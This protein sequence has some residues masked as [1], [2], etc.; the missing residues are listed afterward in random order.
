MDKIEKKEGYD[1]FKDFIVQITEGFE[2]G[3]QENQDFLRNIVNYFSFGET[4]LDRSKGL[5]I[6]GAIGVGK[7]AILRLIQKWLPNNKK[8]AYNPCNEVVAQFNAIGEEGIKVYKTKRDRLFDDLG[9]EE[10]GINY[11]NKI[12]VFE[13]IIYS[14]YDQIYDGMITHFTT[15]LNDNQLIDKYGER[16]F[17]RLKDMCQPITWKGVES[18]RGGATFKYKRMEQEKKEIT[19][20][21]KKAIRKAYIDQCFLKPYNSMKNNGRNEFDVQCCVEFFKMLYR[22][23][24]IMPTDEQIKDCRNRALNWIES[25]ETSNEK[26]YKKARIIKQQI[27]DL[28]NGETNEMESKVKDVSAYFFFLDY[29]RKLIQDNTNIKQFLETNNF[30]EI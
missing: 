19:Q 28:R 20:E 7:T 30:Y 13:K 4:T 25:T 17:D 12:E 14:R 6:R 3:N 23:L 18:K 29:V 2:F 22:D 5:L 16:A 26:D 8:F 9:A 24:V 11:G 10:K 27:A 15:N 1:H 21:E